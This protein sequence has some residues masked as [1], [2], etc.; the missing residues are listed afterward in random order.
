MVAIE[1][2]DSGRTTRTKT[3]TS[4]HPSIRAA[5][6]RLSGIPWKKLRMI[7]KLKAFTVTGRISAHNVSRSPSFETTMKVG[8]MPP[9]NSMV[10]MTRKLTVRRRHDPDLHRGLEAEIGRAHV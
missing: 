8:I 4:E 2:S 3:P 9:L 10:K 6:S 5:S 1:A 7:T